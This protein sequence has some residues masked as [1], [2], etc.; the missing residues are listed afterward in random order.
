MAQSKDSW[1][2]NI[3][4]WN[5]NEDTW[6]TYLEDVEWFFHSQENKTRP[7]VATRLARKLT[8]P[9]RNALKGLKA[10]DFAGI[11]GIPKL[12][13]ILQARIGDLPVP[14]LAH[15]L[16]EFI[17][18]LRRK[19]GESMNEWGLRSIEVYRKLTIALDRVKGK[20]T[21][22][23][24]FVEEVPEKKWNEF[25]W[26][27]EWAG[28]EYG[29]DENGDPTDEDDDDISS[30]NRQRRRGKNGERRKADSSDTDSVSSKGSR[31]S[32][33]GSRSSQKG[34]KGPK[35]EDD[36]FKDEEGFL[37]TEVRGWLLLRNAGLTYSE[38]ATVIAST[39]GNLEFAT[40]FRALR[41][42]YPPRDLGKI[43]EQRGRKGRGKG[44]AHEIDGLYSDASDMS[45]D[46]EESEF[47]KSI[48]SL[49]IDDCVSLM[50]VDCEGDEEFETLQGE[51]AE[52]MQAVGQA[53]KSL[54]VARKAIAQAKLSRG[55]NPRKPL[56]KGFKK[57]FGKGSVRKDFPN[58]PAPSSNGSGPCYICGGPHNY[59][60]CPDRNAPRKTTSGKIN[61]VFAVSAMDSETPAGTDAAERVAEQ[62]TEEVEVLSTC[63]ADRVGYLAPKAKCQA[64]PEGEV[65]ISDSEDVDES[66]YRREH[67]ELYS[68]EASTVHLKVHHAKATVEPVTIGCQEGSTFRSILVRL[69]KEPQDPGKI[70]IGFRISKRCVNL[71]NTMVDVRFTACS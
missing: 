29:R 12:L 71:D 62:V 13:R 7:L 22:I 5:G 25:P 58:K 69:R 45:G 53:T 37:P 65:R 23:E 43:D 40:I 1:E 33:S 51:E 55:F 44:T 21:D 14:D 38:R 24:I 70:L 28:E 57:G 35:K 66:A 18:K 36:A 56:P 46:E 6:N 47:R 26:P 4:T 11:E 2:S 67:P 9:A 42:Q 8:G 61:F 19:P 32:H 52:A 16:D 49:E 31:S 64:Q 60:S 68:V 3:P 20:E 54:S 50:N 15:K 34:A 30:L 10:K 63:A 59:S 27:E 17:F 39:Q 41:Q 48:N